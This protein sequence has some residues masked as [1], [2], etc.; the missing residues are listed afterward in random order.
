M[1]QKRLVRVFDIERFA[2]EDGPGIRTVIFL[3]GCLLRCK[4]CANPESQQFTPEIMYTSRNCK[5]CGKCI[6]HCPSSAISPHIT[7]GLLTDKQKCT[8]CENCISQCYYNARKLVG[9]DYSVDEVLEK[10]MKDKAYY[11]TSGGGITF[12]GGEPFLQSKGVKEIAKKIKAAGFTVLVETCGQAPLENIKECLPYIDMIY[13][14]IKHMNAKKHKELTGYTNEK[15][16]ENLLWLEQNFK[17]S[18]TIRYPYIPGCNDKKEDIK[19]FLQW[20]NTL[21]KIEVIEFLPYHRLGLLKYE[22]IGK[23]YEMKEVKSLK[24][25]DL[26]YILELE[27]KGNKTIRIH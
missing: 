7:F 6:N 16:I 11:E 9:I 27:D 13:F 8:L 10:V 4:W 24:K 17:G 25:A 2:T 23:E 15:I 20:V 22:G 19:E 1:T 3:K 14:D 18:L 12:S 26:A 5:G 21:E